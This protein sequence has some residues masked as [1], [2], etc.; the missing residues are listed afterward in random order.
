MTTEV[1]VIVPCY[2]ESTTILRLLEAV[3]RQDFPRG[4]LEVVIADGMSSDGT[5]DLIHAFA[6][7]HPDSRID[8]VE[9]PGRSIPSALNRAID[10]AKGS[11]LLRLDAHSAPTPDYVARC[12]RTLEQTAAANVGGQW[13]IEPGAETWIA[14]SI[15]AAVADPLG[16]GDARYRTGGPA[17]PVDTVP[18]GAFPRAWIERVGGYDETLLANEDYELNWRLRQ[19][20][21]TI[22]F[23]PAIRCA[24]LARPRLVDLARQYA[25]YGFW[26]A[27]MLLRHPASLRWRQAAP[28]GFVLGSL[29]LALLGGLAPFAWIV[30]G[31]VWLAYL[32]ALFARSTAIAR[33]RRS[34]SLVLGVPLALGIIHL[35]WGAAFL[36]GG[37]TGLARRERIHSEAL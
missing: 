25:R 9:N 6:S 11:V 26:K 30:L 20:G 3:V 17:G 36:V 28:A 27:R 1:S 37:L 29:L 35:S 21:G 33:R 32:L 15:A 12:V 4:R 16:A 14:R 22:W 8:I 23:D 2:N 31:A 13:R 10:A 24:Y 19:A 5:R 7:A 18:F 34:A